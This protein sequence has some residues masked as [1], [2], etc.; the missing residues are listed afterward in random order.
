MT[1]P[2]LKAA[3]LAMRRATKARIK[4]ILPEERRHASEQACALLRA[5]TLW[6]EAK[7]VL[8]FAPSPAELDI[9]PLAAEALAA[10]KEVSLPRFAEAQR[11]YQACQVRALAEELRPGRYGILEP[12]PGCAVISLNQLDLILVPGVAFDLQGR[13]LGRGS[14]FYDRLLSAVRGTTC[15]VGFEEQ[16]VSEV[17]VEAHDVHL[18]CILTPMRWVRLSA[19]GL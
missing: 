16:I 6:H 11:A 2:D 1:S 3:K 10:G 18:N 7:S 8:F 4:A 12:A 17:P 9:W 15:G 5:Q 19:G 14:G 13:R